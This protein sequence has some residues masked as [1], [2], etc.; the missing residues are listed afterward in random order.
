VQQLPQQYGR[1]LHDLHH[2]PH[3]RHLQPVR[4]L[5]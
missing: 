3:G 2:E 4:L 1:E 5:P